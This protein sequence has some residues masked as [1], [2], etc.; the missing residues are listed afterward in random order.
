MLGTLLTPRLFSLSKVCSLSLETTLC[1]WS[2]GTFSNLHN[3]AFAEAE[4]TQL[5]IWLILQSVNINS[6]PFL[7]LVLFLS[8]VW[9]QQTGIHQT[10]KSNPNSTGLNINLCGTSLVTLSHSG[11]FSLTIS[12]CS[13]PLMYSLIRCSI[14]SVILAWTSSF[15]PVSYGVQYTMPSCSLR[16]CNPPIYLYLPII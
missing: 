14:Y 13:L 9:H 12:H 15:C 3:L 2:S 1:V 5:L 6:H 7:V 4:F 10:T 11:I 16:K 8:L